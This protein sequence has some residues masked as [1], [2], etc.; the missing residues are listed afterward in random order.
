MKSNIGAPNLATRDMAGAATWPGSDLRVPDLR[1]IAGDGR[2]RAAFGFLPPRFFKEAR[3]RFIAAY[4]DQ[5][6]SLVSR[7]D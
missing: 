3:D 2:E 7:P 4:R 6:A 1:M 5:R